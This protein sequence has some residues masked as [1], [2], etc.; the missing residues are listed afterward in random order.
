M[1]DP[2]HRAYFTFCFGAVWFLAL[3]ADRAQPESWPS[4]FGMRQ[5]PLGVWRATS[6]TLWAFR[7]IPIPGLNVTPP[8]MRNQPQLTALQKAQI[9]FQSEFDSGRTVD[10]KPLLKFFATS[11]SRS[12]RQILRPKRRG[13]LIRADGL[14]GWG[15]LFSG[16]KRSARPVRP[17]GSSCAAPATN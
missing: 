4:F 2:G 8:F 16:C 1:A 11:D 7:R 12:R 13:R 9:L 15:A 5:A 17:R 6:A 10:D 14:T 3:M